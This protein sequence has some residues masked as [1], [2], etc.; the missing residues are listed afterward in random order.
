MFTRRTSEILLTLAQAQALRGVVRN[1]GTLVQRSRTRNE[2]VMIA[3]LSA[4][5]VISV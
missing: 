1:P 3:L 5:A 2:S 4:D